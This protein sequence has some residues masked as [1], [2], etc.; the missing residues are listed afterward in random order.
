MRDQWLDAWDVGDAY[1]RYMGRWSRRVADEFITWL[2]AGA[3]LRWLDVGCGTGALTEA[4]AD[5]CQPRLI[6]GV[7]RSESFVAAAATAAPAPAG[8]AVAD[9]LSLPVPDRACDVAVSGLALN[10]FPDPAVAVAEAARAVKP[11]GTV[12]AYVWD[13]TQGMAFLRFFWD[14]AVTVDPAAAP[15][16][17]GRRFSA[18]RRDRLHTL[19]TR[20]GLTE[21]GIDAIDVPTSFAG[22][23]EFWVPF[24]G[25][26][27]PA[28]GYVATL[29]P[30]TRDL[31]RDT[32]SRTAPT[33]PDGSIPFT[34]RAW[35]IRGKRTEDRP[36]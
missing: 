32:L 24:L 29:T 30:T 26:Q 5:R 27:G 12:A 9:A 35:A 34:A 1:D 17:E 19:W 2:G 15:L 8:F 20:A 6:L 31:L 33:R 21:V 22:F 23:D 11:G 14:T 28:P 36:T 16:D 13:Y 10:F 4:V 25:G 3:G 7:D 18:C